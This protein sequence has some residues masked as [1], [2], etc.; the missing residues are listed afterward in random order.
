MPTNRDQL[1]RLRA[2][3]PVPP[4]TFDDVVWTASAQALFERIVADESVPARRA[5]VPGP[6]RGPRVAVVAG[7]VGASV[8]VAGYALVGRPSSKPETVA[9]FATPDLAALTAVVGVDAKG[10]V[11]ACSAVWAGGFFGTTVPTLRACLLESGVVGVFPEA[12]G[13]DVCLDLGLVAASKPVPLPAPGGGTRPAPRPDVPLLDTDRFLVFREVVV[14][15]LVDAGCVAAE[16]AEA[17]VREELARAGLEGWSVRA[18][19]GSDG[20]GFS[21][22]RPCAS[23]GFEP[24]TLT[25][26]LVPVPPPA[27]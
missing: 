2:A 13:R 21:A 15:R 24:E 3:N 17:I 5:P 19:V 4:A 1:D 25:V 7:L 14:A 23:L 26:V 6:R 8:A 12:E 11:A 20:V 22:E 10:P 9:C 16:P 27:G 18:G